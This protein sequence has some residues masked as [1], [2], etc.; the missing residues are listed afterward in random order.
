VTGLGKQAKR[1]SDIQ[2]RTLLRHVEAETGFP[3]RNHVVVLLSFKAGLRAKEIAGVMWRMVCD[4][5]GQVASALALTNVA[6]KGRSGRTI[7]L[8]ADLKAALIKLHDVEQAHDRGGS[9]DFV[10]VF[11]KGATD[12]VTRS[13]S[14][15]YLFREWFTKL[16]FNGASSHSGRRTF[17]TRAARKVSE[18]GGSIRDVQALAGHSSI[19]TTQ[20]Y[21]DSDPEAQRKLIALL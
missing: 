4:T 14:V 18:V 1:L 21:I 9:D 8:H 13:N 6:S 7:P 3:E 19:Q 12:T 16:G 2:L 20:R 11:S 15:Q 10:V 5:E 17:I